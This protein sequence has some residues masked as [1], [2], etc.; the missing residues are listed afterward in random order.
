[1]TTILDAL[2]KGTDYLEKQGV[3]NA[4]LNMQHLLATVVG[5]GRMDLYVNFD[6]S[7]EEHQLSRL[8]QMMRD[9]AA[10]S[11]L[12]HLLGTV[13]FYEHGFICDE[14]AL[15]P[16]PETESLVAHLAKSQLPDEARILDVGCG[17]GV[18]GLSLAAAF[19]NRGVKVTLADV[20]PEALALAQENAGKLAEALEGSDVSFVESDLFSN[21]EGTFHLVV[22][23]L[24]Y[25]SDADMN[26]LSAEVQRDPELALQGGPQGTEIM[27]RFLQDV[28]RY[29]ESPGVVA[30]EFGLGQGP[31][32]LVYA[33]QAGLK[34]V[35]LEKDDEGKERFLLGKLSA[36]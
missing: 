25:I 15:I 29:L 7:L 13:E 3:E 21:V 35:T 28:V 5:C 23:N 33:Q 27:E 26:G 4:R 31:H 9:R 8:R 1:M 18:I 22:A 20:S 12:Q 6:Q 19:S 30:M 14:R 34:N 16:R 32:L 2:Q 24:P 17:S 36:V 10:G 11:P